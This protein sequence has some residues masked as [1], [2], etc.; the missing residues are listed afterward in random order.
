MS[1]P[2]APKK[3]IARLSLEHKLPMLM[4][5]LLLLG[6]FAVAAASYVAMRGTATRT[7][8]EHVSSVALQLR[9]AFHQSTVQM[10]TQIRAAA[11]SPRVAEYARTRAPGAR[12]AALHGCPGVPIG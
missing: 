7:A 4:G 12:S 10:R 2:T 11:D 5:S 9:D 8:S 6:I 3:A 1:I